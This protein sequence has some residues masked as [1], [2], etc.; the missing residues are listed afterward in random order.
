MSALRAVMIVAPGILVS[1]AL[2]AGC[3]APPSVVAVARLTVDRASVPLG[4]TVEATIRF[5]VAPTLGPLHD[6]YRV[7]L[8]VF[9]DNET[10]LSSHEH[11]PPIPTSTWR[12]G[13]SIQYARRIKVPAYPYL[14]PAVIAIGL[15]SPV[16]GE[17]LALA[18][19]DLGQS[20][21][22]VATLTTEPQHASSFIVYD[23]GWHQAE[24]DAFGQTAWHWTTAR[25]VLS[26]RNPHRA[27]R[28]LLDVQGRPEL[29]DRPQ[30]LSLVVGERALRKVALNTNDPAHLDYELTA[31]D[32]GGDDVV[33]LEL[34]VDKTFVPAEHDTSSADTRELGVRVLD[35]YV[36]PLS[37]PRP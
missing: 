4:A 12:P 10:F 14:G 15:H 8:H 13:Q 37:E 26:F 9:D 1:F 5:D 3:A 29:F 16:S 33:R 28:L 24:F 2:Q 21:Y 25:A 36:E 27:T 23:E 17:R 32:L 31:A 6:D 18:G 11:D 22:R 19:D 30:Q 7:F 35:A 20:S 34:L